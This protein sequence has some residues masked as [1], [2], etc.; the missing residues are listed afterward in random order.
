MR[1]L[2]IFLCS[3]FVFSLFISFSFGE[4][5]ESKKMQS[6]DRLFQQAGNYYEMGQYDKAVT[7]YKNILRDGYD[8]GPL[9]YNLGNAYFRI[10]DLANA[11]LSYERAKRIVPR[12]ADLKANYRFARAEVR[13]DVLD[14]RG[15]WNWR[16]LKVYS[17][18]LTINELILILSGTYI[19][20]LLIITVSF[21]RPWILRKF[22]IVTF[23]LIIS[24][25]GNLYIAWHKTNLVGKEAIVLDSE[26]QSKFAPIDSATKFFNLYKGMNIIVLGEKSGWYKVKRSDGKIGWIKKEQVEIV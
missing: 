7:E 15:I 8:S 10:G 11:I 19:V 20:V 18:S 3:V 25:M 12:D 4:S 23:L 5:D 13:G 24:F 2:K 26:I 6:I 1:I 22:S 17:E 21:Y 14:K 9:E 16:P